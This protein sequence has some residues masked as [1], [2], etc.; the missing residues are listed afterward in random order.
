MERTITLSK[1]KYVYEL[2]R[3]SKRNVNIRVS[4]EGKLL[5]SAPKALPIWRIEEV[6]RANEAFVLESLRRVQATERP[7][8]EDGGF[9]YLL[10]ERCPV[11]VTPAGRNCAEEK[12]GGLIIYVKDI[13]DAELIERTGEKCI[14]ERCEAVMKALTARVYPYFKARGKTFPELKFRKMRS[15]W[16]NCRSEKGIVTYNTALIG[17]PVECME[18]VAA[19]ELCHLLHPDHSAAFYAELANVIPDW[20]RRRQLLKEYGRRIML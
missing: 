3:R 20:K 18:Y 12:D 16:G 6:I 7:R 1:N 11:T 10:G 9:V 13:S 17:A 19:H 8:L 15:C 2:S 14:K 4:P 5:V